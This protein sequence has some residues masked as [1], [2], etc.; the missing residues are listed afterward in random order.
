MKLTIKPCTM[1]VINDIMQPPHNL[2]PIRVI[3]ENLEPGKGRVIISCYDA[4]WVGYWGGMGGGTV[5]EY[6]LSSD[7]GHLVKNLGCASVLRK[8]KSDIDYLVRI[9]VAIQ[10]A[11]RQ[12]SES[13]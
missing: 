13:T 6:F 1:L 8:S 5:D 7:A 12:Q 2:D 9:I 10:E 3:I 4:A 11:L